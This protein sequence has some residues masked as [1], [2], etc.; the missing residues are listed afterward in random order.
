VEERGKGCS[1]VSEGGIDE[2][3]E[4]AAE[5]ELGDRG[6]KERVPTVLL[7]CFQS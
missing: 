5:K 2:E 6:Q 4:G 7:R 3:R 1:G